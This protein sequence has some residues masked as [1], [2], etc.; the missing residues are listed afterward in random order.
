MNRAMATIASEPDVLIPLRGGATVRYTVL[1]WLLDAE[2]RGLRFNTEPDGRV[3][4][5]PRDLI[6]DSDRDFCREH[7]HELRAAVRYIERQCEEPL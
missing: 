5:S 1:L 6:L 7:R 4:L 2:E 3:R